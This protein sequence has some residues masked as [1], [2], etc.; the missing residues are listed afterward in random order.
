MSNTQKSILFSPLIFFILGCNYKPG[1]T[2]GSETFYIDLDVTNNSNAIQFSPILH[3]ILKEELSKY[4]RVKL[5]SPSDPH[6]DYSVELILGKYSLKPESFLS[7]DTLVASSLKS[8]FGV[9]MEVTCRQSKKR[10][11]E[12]DYV[13]SSSSSQLTGFD[14]QQD[15][16]LNVITAKKLSNRISRD[17]LLNLL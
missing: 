8:N 12:N 1:L 6:I 9:R 14:H 5:V 3:R 15:M 17:L 13:F 7:Q 10:V 4:P 2:S 16:Q 11:V